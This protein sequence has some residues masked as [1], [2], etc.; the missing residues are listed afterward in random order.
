MQLLIICSGDSS[1]SH[2]LTNGMHMN[3]R[4]K[5]NMGFWCSCIHGCCVCRHSFHIENGDCTTLLYGRSHGSWSTAWFDT[6]GLISPLPSSN[7]DIGFIAVAVARF[8]GFIRIAR[9]TLIFFLWMRLKEGL[10]HRL[11]S[12]QEHLDCAVDYGHLIWLSFLWCSLFISW[13]A[14]SY[15]FSCTQYPI[16]SALSL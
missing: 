10:T 6:V 13:S 12:R 4:L 8:T 14:T 15:L 3:T 11:L 5:S 16:N 7:A 9:F 2:I 1:I